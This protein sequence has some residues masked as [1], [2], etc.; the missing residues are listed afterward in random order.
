[1]RILTYAFSYL[2][3]S[4]HSCLLA[5]V[6][7]PSGGHKRKLQVSKRKAIKMEAMK[8]EEVETGRGALGRIIRGTCTLG[9]SK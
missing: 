3:P 7:A 2:C 1:M 9:K 8:R 5:R 6:M 4:G